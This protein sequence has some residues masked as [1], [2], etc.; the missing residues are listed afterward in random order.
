MASTICVA[1]AASCAAAVPGA[2][3]VPSDA[4]SPSPATKIG[5]ANVFLCLVAAMEYLTACGAPLSFACR[6]QPLALTKQ[7]AA[8]Y[9]HATK[10]HG[11]CTEQINAL[12]PRSAFSR[13]RGL[14]RQAS[15][16]KFRPLQTGSRFLLPGRLVLDF[17]NLNA[18]RPSGLTV[19]YRSK[20]FTGSFG[21]TRGK[22][23]A[24]GAVVLCQIRRRKPWRAEG[25]LPFA[26]MA[27]RPGMD[28]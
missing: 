7:S 28:V 15:A 19:T 5:A 21:S 10:K 23:A 12:S 1:S 8:G 26:E 6:A 11:A 14:T 17:S 20:R 22:N 16:I 13:E 24:S 3:A 9:G 2:A 27:V 4:A 18:V 25:A